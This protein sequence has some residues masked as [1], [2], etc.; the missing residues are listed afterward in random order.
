MY[1]ENFYNNH[2]SLSLL[3]HSFRARER[4]DDKLVKRDDQLCESIAQFDIIRQNHHSPS[5][6]SFGLTIRAEASF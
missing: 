6:Y 2:C 3:V 5:S 4:L 1:F